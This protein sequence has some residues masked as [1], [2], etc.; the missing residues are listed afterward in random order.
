[1]KDKISRKWI[2]ALLLF[3]KHPQ[4]KIRCPECESGFLFVKDVAISQWNKIDKYL[5][6]D[7]CGKYNVATR[8]MS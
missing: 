6:C 8:S 4:A 7:S 3:E 5:I 2:D 1:M